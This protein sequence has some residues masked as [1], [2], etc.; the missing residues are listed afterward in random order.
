[1]GFPSLTR[2]IVTLK[3]SASFLFML[4]FRCAEAKFK[5]YF[6]HLKQNLGKIHIPSPITVIWKPQ[7]PYFTCNKGP[8]VTRF[9]PLQIHGAG[10]HLAEWCRAVPKT[11]IHNKCP[12]SSSEELVIGIL[13]AQ[14]TQT[15]KNYKM[16]LK[17]LTIFKN[18]PERLCFTSLL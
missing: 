11:T 1:M 10:C 2:W 16:Q 13:R 6:R 9:M 15:I 5:E 14:L 4:N 18:L 12:E 3:H 7:L 17:P 8:C